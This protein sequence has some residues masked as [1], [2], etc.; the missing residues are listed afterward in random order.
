[1]AGCYFPVKWFFL[2]AAHLHFR[3]AGVKAAA[4]RNIYWV[5]CFPLEQLFIA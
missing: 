1:M 4:G 3:T 2:A 5:G